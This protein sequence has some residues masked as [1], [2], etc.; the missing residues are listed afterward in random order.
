MLLVVPAFALPAWLGIA[1]AVGKGNM[2]VDRQR[3]VMVKIVASAQRIGEALTQAAATMQRFVDEWNRVWDGQAQ[4]MILSSKFR[5]AGPE[6]D[7]LNL[8]RGLFASGGL[9]QGSRI[10][11]STEW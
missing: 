2:V 1:Y 4:T 7:P 9:I 5:E 11:K 10:V 8:G 3:L 6:I